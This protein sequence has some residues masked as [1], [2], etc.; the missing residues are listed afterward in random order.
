MIDGESDWITRNRWRHPHPQGGD[1]VSEV[2][3]LAIHS[4]P[5]LHVRQPSPSVRLPASS[6][7]LNMTTKADKD[8]L[9]LVQ[10]R[11]QHYLTDLLKDD[12]NKYCVDCDAKGVCV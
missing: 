7:L 1:N 12:D 10:D 9:K 5:L 4:D 2:L 8:K 11:C 3:P 6:S